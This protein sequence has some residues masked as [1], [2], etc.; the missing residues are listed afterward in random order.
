MRRRRT[1]FSHMNCVQFLFYY[2]F[3]YLQ[4][5]LRASD[6]QAIYIGYEMSNK[7]ERKMRIIGMRWEKKKEEK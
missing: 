1:S 2:I 6:S 5:F 3:I 7:S 4:Y